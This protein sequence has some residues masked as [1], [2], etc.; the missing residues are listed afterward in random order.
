MTVEE[1]ITKLQKYPS[2]SIV[3]SF[4]GGEPD[5][6]ILNPSTGYM[7]VLAEGGLK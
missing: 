6:V 3:E 5:V 2:G 7:I 4:E 1:L